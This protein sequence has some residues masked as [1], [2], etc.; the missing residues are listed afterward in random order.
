MHKARAAAAS[1]QNPKLVSLF[2]RA[3]RLA[4]LQIEY[5]ATACII[6]YMEFEDTAKLQ[7]QQILCPPPARELLGGGSAKGSGGL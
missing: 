6:I 4:M 3:L 2:F 7:T 5:Q 1:A